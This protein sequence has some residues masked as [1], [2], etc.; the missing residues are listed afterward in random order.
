M[1]FFCYRSPALIKYSQL[2]G[3][4]TGTVA[5]SQHAVRFEFHDCDWSRVKQKTT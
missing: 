3:L 5:F 4:A 1:E 2:S